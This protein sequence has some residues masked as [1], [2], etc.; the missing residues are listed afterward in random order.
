MPWHDSNVMPGHLLWTVLNLIPQI[1]GFWTLALTLYRSFISR[2]LMKLLNRTGNHDL[3]N[4]GS[5]QTVK[6]SYSAGNREKT[7][8]ASN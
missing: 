4:C 2:E 3:D 7:E 6:L 5:S 1:S 8:T